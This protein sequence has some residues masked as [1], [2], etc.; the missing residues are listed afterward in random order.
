VREVIE[1]L[2]AWQKA[3]IEQD[4]ELALPEAR[5]LAQLR[6]LHAAAEVDALTG[7]WLSER[8]D[9]SR[10]SDSPSGNPR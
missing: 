4:D 6:A 7:G 5:I 1:Q 9:L 10:L 3:L 2:F 8:F